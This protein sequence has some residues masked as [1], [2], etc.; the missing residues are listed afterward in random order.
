MQRKLAHAVARGVPLA[1][2]Q[3]G[4]QQDAFECRIWGSLGELTVVASCVASHRTYGGRCPGS[5][6]PSRYQR[7]PLCS[8]LTVLCRPL[9]CSFCRLQLLQVAACKRTGNCKD[10]C[11]CCCC[12]E[13]EA[14]LCLSIPTGFYMVSC[15]P[16][17][18]SMVASEVRRNGEPLSHAYNAVA[19]ILAMCQRHGLM[20]CALRLGAGTLLTRICQIS[21]VSF[22]DHLV[23]S[24]HK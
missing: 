1:Q 11:L 16:E 8:A 15:T 4:E 2:G 22:L 19:G 10:F 20:P 18:R 5:A 14:A 23:C 17:L 13:Q 9:G 24:T 12:R 7:H 3:L 6:Q 21:W